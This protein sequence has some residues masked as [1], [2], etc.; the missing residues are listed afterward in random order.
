M[1]L[2]LDDSDLDALADALAARIIERLRE[3][4]EDSDQGGY[5]APE[6]AARYLGISRKRVYDLRS[7]RAI[8]PDAFDGRTPLFKR[9]T[10]D[11]YVHSNGR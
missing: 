2:A 3:Q 1:Q 5:L 11:S 8:E 6:A 7:M 4:R 9:Q 10:L